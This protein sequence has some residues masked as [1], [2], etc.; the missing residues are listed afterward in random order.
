MAA[1]IQ[2]RRGVPSP[3]IALI[4]PA[5]IIIAGLFLLPVLRILWISVTEPIAGLGNYR[6]LITNGTVHRVAET[7]LWVCSLASVITVIVGYVI[8]YAMVQAT[9]REARVMLFCILLTFWL[10]ILV[11]TFAWVMLLRTEGLVN[12]FLLWSG[13]ISQPLTLV[14]NTFGVIVGMVHVMAP[15]AILPLYAS[16]SGIDRRLMSAARGLGCG[17][18]RSFLYVFLPLSKPGIVAASTLVFIFSLGFFITPSIL[19][20]GKVM[21]IAEYIRLQFET[22]LNWGYAGML[23]TSLLATV[24]LLLAIGSPFLGR[25]RVFGGGGA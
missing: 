3:V 22:T 12:G 7:T 17:P 5:L 18:V 25:Q 4:A 19:G 20:G 11:R 6:L 23:A 13:L 16:L 9:S 24:L 1:L 15:L 8:A 14:R 2:G 10:S 21:M